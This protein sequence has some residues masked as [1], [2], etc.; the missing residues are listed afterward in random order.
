MKLSNLL[1]SVMPVSFYGINIESTRQ[2]ADIKNTDPNAPYDMQFSLSPDP[3]ISSVHY[4]AQDVKPGGMFVAIKGIAADGHDF[5]DEA[6]ARGASVIVTQKPVKK[7]S[8]IIEFE[9]TRKALAAISSRLYSNPSEKLFLIGI[10]GTNGKTTTAFLIESLLSE[11]GIEIGVIGTLNYRYSGKTFQ[12][13]ITTP[14]SLDLQ[15]ILAEML[16]SGITHVVMEVSSH[17]IDLDRI[18][19]CR[20]D[21]L[22]FT[23]LTQDHLDYHG[24]MNSYWSCKKRLFTQISDSVSGNG[25]ILA[26]I[27]HNDEKGKELIKQ[28]EASLGKPSVLSTGFSKR[29][30]IRP[31]GIKHDLTGIS[32]K[33]STPDGSFEFKSPLVGQH[34]LENILCAT[35]VGIVLYL[36]LNSI[37]TGIEAVC[38]V[39]GR[40]E[41]IPNDINRFTYVDYAHTPDALENVLSALRSMAMGRIIC[42]FGC[43]GNR[44]KAKRPQMGQIAGKLCDLSIITSD[45]PRTEPPMEII[46]QI[47]DGTKKATSNTYMPSD[48]TTGFQKK[49]C[50]IEP[51]RKTAIQLSIK[52]SRPGDIVLIAGKGNETYQ[53]IGNNAISFDDREEA[54]TAL[55]KLGDQSPEYRSHGCPEPVTRNSQPETRNPIPWTTA[56]IIEAT[57]GELL[58]GNFKHS[59]LGISI[60]SR[61]ISEDDLFVAI[62]G[63]VHDGHSFTG[64]V[65]RHGVSGLL[66]DRTKTD[67]LPGK[68]SIKSGIVCIT[69]ND[70]TEAL[71]NLAA[72]NRKRSN[73]AVVAITGSNG[74]TSTR[75]MTAD[76]VSPRFC[77]L[78]TSGN[79]NNLIGLP[80][81][82]L[83]LSLNHRWAVLELGMNR[84]GEIKRLAEICSPDIGV[85]TN[86]GP[87]HLEGLGSLDAVMQAK[88]EL[89]EKIKPN[90]TAVLNADDP[91]LLQLADYTSRNVLLFGM[92]KNAAIRAL[93]VKVK[94][95]D[96]SFTLMLPDE[97]ILVYLKTPAVFMVSNALAAAAVCYLLGLTIREIKDGLEDFKPVKAR[98]NILKTGK[99][100]NII[101]DTYNANPDSMKEAINTLMSLKGNNRGVL[102]AGDMLELGEHAE[103]MHRNIGR[104]AAGSDIA[105]LYVTGQFAQTVAAGAMDEDMDSHDIFTGTKQEILEVI[106][107]RLSP[108][109]CILVKGSR[110]MAMETIVQGL[111]DWAGDLNC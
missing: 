93:S 91:R 49:G 44:D 51:D 98:M 87:A 94:G 40:L 80:L 22:I 92:G 50:V 62:K 48:L 33:I 46:N 82:L 70:T 58:L 24:D 54:K 8:I 47:L 68:E 52:V 102:V 65:I 106:T 101:D 78:S 83:N 100:I 72:F 23:N 84:P 27:N 109:D 2:S 60:D 25:R 95:S 71:G 26:V 13:P 1:E 3:E 17:A 77:T 9:N 74:K 111:L 103:S 37:K 4:R 88:G 96:L 36:P 63:E 21:L 66:I 110:G 86:I 55:S 81:T 43:G 73:V 89:L 15:K 59:F 10:T 41:R 99:G 97:S 61:K 16:Q 64:N 39:P 57:G 35:G 69:V 7:K 79:L 56:E 42:V 32:G 53:I 45:N 85:I 28:L 6:L 19:N 34:N 67:K 75:K 20:F 31:R 76:V 107:G 30:G 18:D 108:G 12:N 11:A 104:I 29:N 5:I 38:A 14:E 90:G 105:M